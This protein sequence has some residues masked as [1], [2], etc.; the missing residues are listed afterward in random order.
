MLHDDEVHTFGKRQI[1]NRANVWVV[2]RRGELGFSFKASEV[3]FIRRQLRRQ[4]FDDNGSFERGVDRLVNCALPA[5]A[6]LGNDAIVKELL[7]NH[8][9]EQCCQR[10]MDE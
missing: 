3:Y 1:V 8:K 5:L 6:E 2:E 9:E 10:S 7:P 4:N